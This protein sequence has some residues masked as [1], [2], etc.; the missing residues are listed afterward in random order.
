MTMSHLQIIVVGSIPATTKSGSLEHFIL[1][2]GLWLWF[3]ELADGRGVLG[4]HP[5]NS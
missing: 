1:C 2:S 3:V 4:L 5:A